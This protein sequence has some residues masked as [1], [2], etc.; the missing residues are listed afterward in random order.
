MPTTSQATTCHR[1]I[2][3]AFCHRRRCPVRNAFPRSVFRSIAASLIATVL[4]SSAA[5]AAAQDGTPAAAPGSATCDRPPADPAAIATVLAT[6]A[7]PPS[8]PASAFATEADLPQGEPADAATVAAITEVI[9]TLNACNNAGDYCQAFTLASE[10]L[11]QR[12]FQAQ[13]SPLPTLALEEVREYCAQIV[14]RPPENQVTLVALRDVRVL[15]D[16]RVGAVVVQHVPSVGT[17]PLF[18]VF[19]EVGDR[20]VVD[21]FFQIVNAAPTGSSA[22]T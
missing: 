4:I 16:G 20:W 2:V 6:P 22:A 3:L 8:F 5:F 17:G 12:R 21:G 15:P 19:V 13:G 14:P 9:R 7:P 10:A 1:P 18:V 11:L